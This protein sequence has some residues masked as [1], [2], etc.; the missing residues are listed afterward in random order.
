MS[1]P[2]AALFH[3]FSRYHAL[4]ADAQ[5]AIARICTRVAVKKHGDLQPIG[6]TC[7]TL[8]FVHRG[9]ARIYYFKDEK[10]VTESFAFE[11]S[12]IARVESLFTGRP[13]RKGI[14]VIEDTEFVALPA[15]ALFA[16]YDVFPDIE[17]LFRKIFEAAYVETVNRLESLQFHSAEERYRTLLQ[18]SPDVLRRVPLKYVASYLGITPVSLS[19][20]RGHH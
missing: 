18:E 16:L 20:I 4:P 19:R 1:L 6:H 13:S 12:L 14:H 3:Y 10:D 8:Y 7:R 17:R 5:Q 9:V 2:L 11:G 15:P